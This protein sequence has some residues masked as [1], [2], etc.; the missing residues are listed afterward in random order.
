MSLSFKNSW[1]R[2]FLQLS[3]ST[4]Y[5]SCLQKEYLR[6][7]ITR[8]GN[9]RKVHLHQF[10]GTISILGEVKVVE[11]QLEPRSNQIYYHSGIGSFL[12]VFCGTMAIKLNFMVFVVCHFA[13]LA[14]ASVCTFMVLKL[15]NCSCDILP[16]LLPC[17]FSR[18]NLWHLAI[19][20]PIFQILSPCL[21]SH[22]KFHE[23]SWSIK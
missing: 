3:S 6:H 22:S 1:L 20:F 9:R 19:Q 13:I 7:N 5:E 17:Y 16:T 2:F 23:S 4:S 18:N 10:L 14:V 8:S 11:D 12:G 15:N 21:V